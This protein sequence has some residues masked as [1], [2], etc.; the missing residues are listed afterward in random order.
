MGAH[1]TYHVV[2]SFS[3]VHGSSFRQPILQAVLSCW[4]ARAIFASPSGTVVEVA[5]VHAIDFAATRTRNGVFNSK[6]A[7]QRGFHS[8]LKQVCNR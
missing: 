3:T 8:K 4:E 7:H 2:A 1:K 5:E 6:I